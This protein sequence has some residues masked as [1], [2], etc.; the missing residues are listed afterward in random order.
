M[1]QSF[2]AYTTEIDDVE[3]AVKELVERLDCE[4][5]LRKNTV[6]I[7]SCFSD[8]IGTGVVKALRDTFPFDVLGVTTIANASAGQWG[9]TMLC[10]LVLTSDDVEFVTGLSE[11]VPEEDSSALRLSY[12][13]AARD[14][15]DRPSFMLGFFPL[16]SNAGVDFFVESMDEITGGLPVFGSLPVDH[17]ADYCESRVIFNG[18]AWP[19]RAAFLLFYG[20]VEPRFYKGTLSADKIFPAEGIVTASTGNLIQSVNGKP[21]RDYLVSLGLTKNENGEI[22]GINSFP[23]IADYKD[24]AEPVVTSMLAMTPEGYAVCGRN[25]PVGSTFAI[26]RFLPEGIVAT[27]AGTIEKALDGTQFRTALIFSCVGRYFSLLY[28][29]SAEMEMVVSEMRDRGVSYMMAY[30]GGEVCPVRKDTDKLM[31]RAQS[32]TFIVCTF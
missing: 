24:G 15:A 3:L 16:L 32:N 14:R 30:S 28:D 20:N 21:T 2:S 7:M 5:K 25:V 12:D 8:F 17:N 27:S 29:Q 22:D 6:G 13:E 31:N 26:G 18:E 19:D 9:E 4:G 11:P 10:L 1:I 23:I